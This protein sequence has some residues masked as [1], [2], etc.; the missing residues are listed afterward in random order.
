MDLGRDVGGRLG[1]EGEKVLGTRWWGLV[2]EGLW[3]GFV[4]GEMGE[5]RK[6]WGRWVKGRED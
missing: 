1:Y 5:G 6:S 3:V 4:W 2:G